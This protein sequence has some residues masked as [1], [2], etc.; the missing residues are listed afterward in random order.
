M[1]AWRNLDTFRGT[2]AF[3]TWLYRIASNAALAVVRRRRGEVPGD[4]VGDEYA[5]GEIL[6]AEKRGRR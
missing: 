1:A 5:S 3:G 6:L 4:R 2:A